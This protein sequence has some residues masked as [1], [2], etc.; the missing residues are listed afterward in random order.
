M[1]AAFFKVPYLLFLLDEPPNN[2]PPDEVFFFEP[3]QLLLLLPLE[4][5]SGNRITNATSNIRTAL[6][7]N[8]LFMATVMLYGDLT[9]VRL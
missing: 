2:P 1:T 7:H 8:S 4:S 6:Q 5:A 3:N 9:R